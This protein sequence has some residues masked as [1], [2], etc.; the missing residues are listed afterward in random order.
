MMNVNV[1]MSTFCA[2]PIFEIQIWNGKKHT[3]THIYKLIFILEKLQTNCMIL[4]V[5]YIFFFRRKRKT[6]VAK[7]NNKITISS[8]SRELRD[9]NTDYRRNDLDN[10]IISK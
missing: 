8:F 10:L 5:I 1:Y 9:K 4:Y 3:H 2:M 6:T 7:N